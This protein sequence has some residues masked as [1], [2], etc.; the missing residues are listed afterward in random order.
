MFS[1]L[2]LAPWPIIERE[3][4]ELD[5]AVLIRIAELAESWRA[6]EPALEDPEPF[7]QG[8]RSGWR[9]VP[10][11]YLEDHRSI[12]LQSSAK[13][14]H[15][16]Y[17]SFALSSPEDIYL[18]TDGR[19]ES[20]ERY[21]RDNLAFG[22]QTI[23]T[24]ELSDQVGLADSRNTTQPV[25]AP[26]GIDLALDADPG[27]TKN[28]SLAK[29]CLS[30]DDHMEYLASRARQANGLNI[31]PFLVDSDIWMLADE[32]HR[33]SDCLITVMG[34]TP[35]LAAR[36][37]DKLW[38][39]DM[40]SAVLG[41]QHMPRTWRAYTLAAAVGELR[42]LAQL[43]PTVVLKTTASAGSQG[44]LVFKSQE[45]LEL[46]EADCRKN[47]EQRLNQ[48]GWRDDYPLLTA[49]WETPVQESPS[50]QI[51][52]P[53]SADGLPVIEG[54][55]TQ[56]LSGPSAGF[57]GAK[58]ADLPLAL[59]K[60]MVYEAGLLA[61]CLQQLGYF[62]RV[63]FDAIV[64]G[65]DLDHA[66][67]HWIECNARWGGV[68]IPM[69]V[70]NRLAGIHGYSASTLRVVQKP[71]RQV[72]STSFPHYR[73]S[74]GVDLLD[75]FL[76]NDGIVCLTPVGEPDATATLLVLAR[77]DHVGSQLA[78]KAVQALDPSP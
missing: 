75:V 4:Y 51:W 7:G 39:F 55:F 38:F 31:S 70:F 45:L 56:N 47:I 24:V 35:R 66:E 34:P 3:K 9:A 37:N 73:D 64:V 19:V 21:Q 11:L 12:Q 43:T 58:P 74:L 33:R 18:R 77:S 8:V 40:A 57:I 71:Q 49:S 28:H 10:T 78:V 1:H 63:S 14:R 54:L 29:A 32:L 16:E 15:F 76:I 20:F 26:A 6:N 50:A 2:T 36:A 42:Y 41:R 46:S 22:A 68:S 44:N 53:S 30:N 69:T 25:N 72:T 5:S 48:A 67:L 13:A 60:Q 52:I 23:L 59:R 61:S 62:G 65:N 17:R 27:A